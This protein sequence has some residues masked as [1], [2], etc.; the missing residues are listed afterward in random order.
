MIN[1]RSKEVW[2]VTGSQHLYGEETLNK[3]AEHSGTI[4]KY[5]DELTQVPVNVIFKPVVNTPDEIAA[6]CRDANASQIC[7][8]VVAWMH[9]FSPAKMWIN[10]LKSLQKPML[11]LH[12]Q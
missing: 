4:A 7:I 3:V 8:G 5:L 12:T 1:L 11:H 2:F 10:G 9:T 6:I